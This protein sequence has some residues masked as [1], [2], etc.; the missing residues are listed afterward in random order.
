MELK[1]LIISLEEWSKP[2]NQALILEKIKL[3]LEEWS[4]SENREIILDII[5]DLLNYNNR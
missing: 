5:K 2:E 3:S 4:G 1:E